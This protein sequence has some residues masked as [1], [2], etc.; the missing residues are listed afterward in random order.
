MSNFSQM[1]DP[2]LFSFF[3]DLHKDVAG[4]RPHAGWVREKIVEFCEWWTSPEGVAELKQQW[5]EEDEYFKELERSWE[6][7]NQE[8]VTLSELLTPSRYEAM[9]ERA[10]YCFI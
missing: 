2:E 7:A 10:G 8:L 9:A 3:S 5:A 6:E 1:T 4:F